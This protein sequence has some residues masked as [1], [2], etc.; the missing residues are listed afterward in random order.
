MPRHELQAPR[1][2]GQA[3]EPGD[4]PIDDTGDLTTRRHDEAEGGQRIGGLEVADQR[5]G[6]L[7]A[8]PQ[9]LDGKHLSGRRRLVPQ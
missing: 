7:V 1:R 5:Q 8:P 9:N 6:D 4:G 3:G 2:P